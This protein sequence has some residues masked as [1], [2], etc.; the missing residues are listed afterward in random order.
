MNVVQW[1]TL[2]IDS[3][4]KLQNF[5]NFYN[6]SYF[7]ANSPNHCEKNRKIHEIIINN[8]KHLLMLKL[9]NLN[10]S[11][12][13]P[14]VCNHQTDMIH[15]WTYFLFDKLI[16]NLNIVQ[17]LF[18]GQL[19]KIYGK[20]FD[21][22]FLHHIMFQQTLTEESIKIQVCSSFNLYMILQFV[23]FNNGVQQNLNCDLSQ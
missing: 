18:N 10:V 16:N 8:N 17:K 9:I 14:I 21:I 11:E 6:S 2:T 12:V 23:S 1:Q 4:I 3:C 13:F 20:K 15:F 22:L 7:P 5:N 19:K